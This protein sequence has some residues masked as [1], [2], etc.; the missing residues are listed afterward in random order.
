MLQ[1]DNISPQFF[2]LYISDLKA[3]LG[4]DDDTP[5]LVSTPINCLMY[6]DDLV[7]MSRSESGLQILLN[8]LGEYC[9]KWRMEVNIKKTKAMKFSGNGHKCKSVFIYNGKPLENVAK[10]KY[11]G[12]EFSSSGS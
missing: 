8:R 9:R 12:I 10:Y 6:A 11:L 1:G 7:L 2:N 4:V 5:K 3:F